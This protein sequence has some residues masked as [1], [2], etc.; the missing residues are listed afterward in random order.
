MPQ[1]GASTAF[2]RVRLIGI[3]DGEVGR[4]APAVRKAGHEEP[5][6]RTPRRAVG[7]PFSDRS[8]ASQKKPN[9]PCGTKALVHRVAKEMPTAVALN[10]TGPNDSG[11]VSK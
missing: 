3:Y 6:S 4:P 7:E 5:S 10:R 2:M 1:P 11:R 9:R 8:G